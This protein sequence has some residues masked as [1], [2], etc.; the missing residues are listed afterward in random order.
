MLAWGASGRWFESSRPD[1]WKHRKHFRKRSNCTRM[2]EKFI[3]SESAAGGQDEGS[4]VAPTIRLAAARRVTLSEPRSGE[5]KN[6]GLPLAHGKPSKT[7]ST[8]G[9]EIIPSDWKRFS[10]SH[11]RESRLHSMNTPE[12]QIQ[13]ILERNRRV[14]AGRHGSSAGFGGSPSSG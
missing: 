8:S 14:E 1:H 4:P 11:I 7:N 3:P 6:L 13:A 5:S 9:R 12:Q 2:D 10:S